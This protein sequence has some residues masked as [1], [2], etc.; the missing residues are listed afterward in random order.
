MSRAEILTGIKHAEE[1]GA[2]LVLRSKEE[3]TRKISEA[4]VQSREIIKKAED[5][6]SANSASQ[7]SK[8]REIARIERE[9]VVEKGKKEAQEIKNKARKNIAKSNKFIL[10]EFERAVNA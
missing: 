10:A 9:K 8:A 2:N 3:K 7:I 1:E 4:R 5:A 6:A